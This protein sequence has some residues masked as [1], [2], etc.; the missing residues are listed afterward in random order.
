VDGWEVLGRLRNNPPTAQLPIMVCSILHQE[1]L[2]LTLGADLFLRKPIT[3]YDFLASLD[4][5]VAK[6]ELVD[7]SSSG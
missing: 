4:R 7:H 3:R 6:R 5:L 1:E 2:A